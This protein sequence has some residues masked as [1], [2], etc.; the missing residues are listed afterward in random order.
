MTR[1]AR[2]TLAL[3]LLLFVGLL[4]GCDPPAPA[5]VSCFSTDLGR[6]AGKTTP[7]R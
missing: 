4:A 3:S 2:A 6:P 1:A 5:Q 7:K